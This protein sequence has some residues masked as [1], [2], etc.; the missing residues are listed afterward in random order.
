M[1]VTLPI[2]VCRT[3]SLLIITSPSRHLFIFMAVPE[4][5]Q[6]QQLSSPTHLASD[7]VYSELSHSGAF[8]SRTLLGSSL[9]SMCSI[10]GTF[11]VAPLPM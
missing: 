11:A 4:Q 9:L 10:V 5:H 7:C 1:V 6:P 2:S 8:A 3:A